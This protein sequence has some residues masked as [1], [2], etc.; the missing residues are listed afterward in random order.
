M[1]ANKAIE[2][3]LRRRRTQARHTDDVV[4]A[5]SRRAV[6]TARDQLI[7]KPLRSRRKRSRS[8]TAFP[9]MRL[10]RNASPQI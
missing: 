3:A 8:A 5:F 9:S 1:N 2:W 10:C 4:F 7:S 6:L